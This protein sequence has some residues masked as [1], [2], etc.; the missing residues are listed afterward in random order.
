MAIA[1]YHILV[2]GW[3]PPFPSDFSSLHVTCPCT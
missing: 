1:V 2:C 3:A